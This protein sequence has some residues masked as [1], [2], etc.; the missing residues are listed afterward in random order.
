MKSKAS[1]WVLTIARTLDSLGIDYKP[2]FWKVGMDPNGLKSRN[3]RYSETQVRGLW[4]LAVRETRGMNFGLKVAEH[5]RPST[6]DVV[7]YSMTC[8]ATLREAMHRFAR[9][10][11]LISNSATVTVFETPDTLKVNFDFD[12]GG[13]TQP[14]WQAVDTS[15]AGLV[16]FISWI[17]GSEIAPVAVYFRHK[18]PQDLSEYQ[19]FL[20]CPIHFSC[21]ENSIIFTASDMD[22]PILSADEQLAS[23][24]D[25]VAINNMAEVNERFAKRVR[26]CL[27]VQVSEGQISR[28][29]T[30]QLMNMTERTL[31][32]RLKGEGTTFQE[33]LD[34]L[35]EELA[36]DYLLQPDMTIQKVSSLLGFSEPSTFSRAFKRW[37]GHSPSVNLYSQL[38]LTPS[39]IANNNNHHH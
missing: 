22:R 35:R 27:E 2:L 30:A 34:K 18:G 29:R 24:L 38:T 16:R 14:V 39:T 33:V 1:G 36:Y 23:L 17:A 10:E 11:K 31:L 13:G 28:L 9:F 32:R 15:L 3:S 6:F 20:T 8:S 4:Q 21:D 7:G 12:M 19:K 25:T 26:D 5:I 37:T